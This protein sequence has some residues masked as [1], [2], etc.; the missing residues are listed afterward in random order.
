MV[1]RKVCHRQMYSSPLMRERLR[2]GLTASQ[3]VCR[4]GLSS[5]CVIS[6]IETGFT[7]CPQYETMRKICEALGL[8][9]SNRNVARFFNGEGYDEL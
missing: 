8:T 5:A 4:A 7:K 6:R 1:A 9:F 3:L 2:Q